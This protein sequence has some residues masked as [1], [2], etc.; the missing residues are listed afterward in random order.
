MYPRNIIRTSIF[1]PYDRRYNIV[2]EHHGCTPNTFPTQV[3]LRILLNIIHPYLIHPFSMASTS[4]PSSL[5][6]NH[7]LS[8]DPSPPRQ[9]PTHHHPL[10]IQ[11]SPQAYPCTI[12]TTP[13]FTSVQSL[14]QPHVRQS[15]VRFYNWNLDGS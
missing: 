8:H 11:T 13:S 1:T 14:P 3:I 5:C 7:T 4:S 15:S 6:P 12:Q 10:S 9:A 2:C